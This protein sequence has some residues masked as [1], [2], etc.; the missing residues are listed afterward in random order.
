FRRPGNIEWGGLTLPD[1]DAAL[2]GLDARIAHLDVVTALRQT[3]RLV[4]AVVAGGEGLWSADER[5][6]RDGDSGSRHRGAGG[7]F[8]GVAADSPERLAGSVERARRGYANRE[9]EGDLRKLV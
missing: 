9:S 4:A 7:R 3:D 1:H 6:T 8:S 5:G 2:D